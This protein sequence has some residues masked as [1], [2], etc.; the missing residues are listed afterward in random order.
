MFTITKIFNYIIFPPAIFIVILFAALY[1]INKS[2]KKAVILILADIILLY[3]LSIE[4]VKNII[5]SPLEKYAPPIN[6]NEKHNA[7]YIVILGGGTINSSPEENGT[8]S[9]T[10][11]S[12]KRAVY[13]IYLAETLKIPVIFSGGKLNNKQQESESDIAVK[14]MKRYASEKVILIAEDQS[15]TT[16]EN[17]MLVKSRYNPQKIILVTS[18]YHMK[19]SLYS[20]NKA[21]I[22][23]IPAPTD[24]KADYFEYNATSFIPK[25]N[26]MDDIYKAL[27]EYVGL[28]FYRFK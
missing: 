27:K 26:E 18:A 5:I 1:Y 25:T 19:R 23:C 24:Y 20:F 14:I 4:P 8:G 7:D 28:L 2:R 13:G 22:T 9:L 15:R 11:D 17:A 16:F 12:L 10:D 3:I 6:L 21:G